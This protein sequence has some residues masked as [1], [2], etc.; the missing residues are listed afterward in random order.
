MF[1]EVMH[2]MKY[3]VWLFLSGWVLSCNSKLNLP[4]HPCPLPECAPPCPIRVAL[5]LGGGGARGISHVGVLE[6]FERAGIPIDALVGCSAGSIVGAL[7]ADCMDLDTLR[8][9]LEPLAKWD[10]LDINI[11]RCRYG[12]VQGNYLDKF[13]KRN[14]RSRC[15]EELHIP[16]YA[17]STDLIAGELVTIGSGPLIPAVRASAAVPFVFCPVILY[18]RMLVDGGVADPVPVKAARALGADIVVAVDLSELLPKTCPTSLFGIASRSAE[19]KLLLEAEYCV[20]G[21]DVIIRPE[22]GCLSM[23]DTDHYDFAYEAGRQAA[24]EAI[25]EVLRLLAE[26]NACA[27][28]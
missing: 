26:K 5:V 21:A 18:D 4:E 20:Q 22:L 8:R 9:V 16:F 2:Y 15:F 11:W 25:P 12:L 13:L 24:R 3:L 27:V 1:G 6:E 23:F 28:N 10:I 7:Y 14:L 17:V 19:L